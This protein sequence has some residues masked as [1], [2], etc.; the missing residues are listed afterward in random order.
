MIPRTELGRKLLEIREKALASGEVSL[1]SEV[2]ISMMDDT[3][4]WKLEAASLAE[5]VEA[6]RQVIA[7]LRKKK[8]EYMRSLQVVGANYATVCARYQE[9]IA[10]LREENQRLNVSIDSLI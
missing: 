7:T 4:A 9:E 1:L 5:L 10:T 8:K 3:E 6:Q 2:E